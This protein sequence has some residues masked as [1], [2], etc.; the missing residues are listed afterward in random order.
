[1]GEIAENPLNWSGKL[2]Q[3]IIRR[4]FSLGKNFISISGKT[5]EDLLRFITNPENSQVV[6]NGL[7][8]DF[9]ITE[10]STAR[11]I[12][13]IKTNFN[14]RNGYILHVGGNQFYKN[15]SGVIEIYNAWRLVN[16]SKTPLLLVGK[17]PST[18]LLTTYNESPFKEDIFFLSGL[19]D[20]DVKL[21][22]S[23]ATLFLFPSLE[24]G[25]GWPIAEA[26]AS[27][28]PV[29]TTNKAPMT[30]VAGKAGF[31]INRRPQ[32]PSEVL[33]WAFQSAKVVEFVATLSG[34]D[35]NEIIKKGLENV[36]RFDREETLNKIEMIYYNILI[37]SGAE[38]D[39]S[40]TVSRLAGQ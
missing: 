40:L 18:S 1:L 35:R 7:N 14:L 13:G 4:G 30:E 23:G 22:Y 28:C 26:M 39:N 33:D 19:N 31:F 21:A 38:A 16:N 10:A 37:Q 6:Y 27:G 8:Q 36:K 2:Y 3:K 34:R 25:F 24:E 5:H 12:L 9:R 17:S 32:N 11:L 20:E 29:V 15:R